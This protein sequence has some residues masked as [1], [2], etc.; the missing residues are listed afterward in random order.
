MCR[1]E[2][3]D[4]F[5]S[6]FGR[7]Y[8]CYTVL[9]FSSRSLELFVVDARHVRT[10]PY[11]GRILPFCHCLLPFCVKCRRRCCN[12]FYRSVT[13]RALIITS[14]PNYP[15]TSDQPLCSNTTRCL[16]LPKSRPHHSHPPR[17]HQR[18]R[19][20]CLFVPFH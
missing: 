7:Y 2:K 13:D 8:P 1:T 15:Q 12:Y 16:T 9:F 4:H 11:A 20:R 14:P 3:G 6:C 19:V 10:Y 17:A 5:L 18:Q